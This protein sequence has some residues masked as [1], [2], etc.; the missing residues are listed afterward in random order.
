[1]LI[2]AKTAPIVCPVCRHKQSYF[3]RK[4]VTIA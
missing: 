1:M 2:K 4:D 3:V